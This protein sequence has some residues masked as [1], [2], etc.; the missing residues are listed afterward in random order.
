M[1]KK[2]G[3]YEIGRTLGEGTFGVS[4]QRREEAPLAGGL[5]ARPAAEALL[6]R[7]CASRSADITGSLCG[8]PSAA[9][10]I[11]APAD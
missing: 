1:V 3:K 7:L 8:A 6:R 11:P 2:V 10:S 5:A 4:T 9:P